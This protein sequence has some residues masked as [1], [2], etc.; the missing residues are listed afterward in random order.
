MISHTH[1]LLLGLAEEISQPEKPWIQNKLDCRWIQINT[2]NTNLC[3]NRKTC[4]HAP[5]C[6]T[7]IKDREQ[8]LQHS[9]KAQGVTRLTECCARILLPQP[10]VPCG[11]QCHKKSASYHHTPCCITVPVRYHWIALGE[12]SA[13]DAPTVSDSISK[14]NLEHSI[15][16]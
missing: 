15:V 12:I 16:Q 6:T 8:W 13:F 14:S 10:A 11:E 1:E 4:L 9:T 2:L 7:K 5:S 3:K